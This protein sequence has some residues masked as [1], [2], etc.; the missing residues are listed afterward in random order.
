MKK[1][2]HPVYKEKVPVKCSCGNSFTTG[3]TKEIIEVE[4]CSACHPFYT[5]KEKI[6]D[7]MRRVEKF[8]KRIEKKKDLEKK[9]K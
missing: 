8:R 4:T 6:V 5:G 2:I 9:T 1:E 7:A 3:S